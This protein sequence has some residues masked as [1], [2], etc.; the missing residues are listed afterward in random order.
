MCVQED[1]IPTVFDNY[2]A[3]VTV[4]G[5]SVALG[6]WD[7]AGAE[8][9]GRLRPLT[10][11][12]TDVFLIA[13]SIISPASYENVLS[14][15]Y[16][17]L[18]DQQAIDITTIPIILV[19]TKL[20]LR[21][22]PGTLAKLAEKSL[23]PVSFEKGEELK[24]KIGARKYMECCAKTQKGVKQVFDEAIRAK[25]HQKAA[26][27]WLRGVSPDELRAN[28]EFMKEETLARL[29]GAT[30]SAA[31]RILCEAP[32]EL[33]TDL[34]LVRAAYGVDNTDRQ[35][36]L[37]KLAEDGGFLQHVL[38]DLRPDPEV[39]AAAKAGLIAQLA[40]GGGLACKHPPRG[41]AGAAR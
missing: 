27:T 4:D 18:Q 6:L 12:N 8:D 26:T 28:A 5:K 41:A 39:V 32:P 34:E 30:G 23:A 7:V 3:N 15:W 38:S 16:K 35:A 25:L 17:E 14:K 21:D 22:D 20:D 2:S 19:G 1:Y 40:G 9:Y 24:G 31:T 36:V 29:A 37:V 11:P 13:F 33:Q 10:Y